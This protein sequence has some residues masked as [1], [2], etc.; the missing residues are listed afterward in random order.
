MGVRGARRRVRD[1]V[2]T[3]RS[4]VVA[5]VAVGLLCA[6]LLGW[7]TLRPPLV[8]LANNGDWYRYVCPLGM[9]PTPDV[10]FV[11]VPDGLVEG[12]CPAE[13]Y[14]SSFQVV[15]RAAW[16]VDDAVTG[17]PLSMRVLAGGWSLV[18]VAGWAWLAFELVRG[19][20]R[21]FVPAL[22][23]AGAVIVASDI[24]FS[25]YYASGYA[26]AMIFAVAPA[27]AAG[28]A[29][30]SGDRAPRAG[31]VALTLVLLVFV[32][33]SKPQVALTG[34]VVAAALASAWWQRSRLAVLGV[35]AVALG[36]A[37]Y[38]L[39]LLADA[40]YDDV[41]TVNLLFSAVLVEADDP[42]AT[43]ESF[44]VPAADAAELATFAGGGYWVPPPGDDPVIEVR[45]ITPL[46]SPAFPAIEREVGRRELVTEIVTEPSVASAMARTAIVSLDTTRPSYLANHA[47]PVSAGRLADRPAPAG[48]LLDL[49]LVLPWWAV[50][51]VWVIAVVVA[52]RWLWTGLGP[53]R[54]AG[55]ALFL[56]AATA[57][58]QTVIAVADGYYELPKHL[59]IAQYANAVL[60]A[61]GLGAALGWLAHG[62]ERRF[63]HDD[64]HPDPV[65]APS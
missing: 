52:L 2:A 53:A 43:L 8:G 50:P 55:A 61:A 7:W 13:P 46:G 15:L 17:E 48:S 34:L 18:A 57:A 54:S 12:E 28:T 26:E 4:A 3:E 45:P 65:T 31:A 14:R 27:L 62:A 44:G 5:A 41:N 40:S 58:T 63:R 33:A 29:R 37:V 30:L 1:L 6:V 24:A 60:I 38:S 10:F 11:E 36:S 56:V 16:F 32:V 9:E 42:A 59:V 19:S 20:R 21:P 22:A 64:R 35:V 23:T 39:G 25:A 49:L 47:D 51:A